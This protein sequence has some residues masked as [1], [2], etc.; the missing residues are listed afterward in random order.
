MR[1]EVA[2]VGSGPAGF[3]VAE[4]LLRSV[5]DCRIDLYERLPAPYGLVRYGVAPDHQ[6]L[7]SVTAIFDRIAADPRIGLAC[8]VEVGVDI[9]LAELRANHHCVI[10]ACGSPVGRTLGI[11]GE[12]LD[13]VQSSAN[14]VG[15][16][17]GHPDHGG[18][19]PR[20]DHPVAVVAG[21]GNVAMDVCRLLCKDTRELA[22]YDLTPDALAAFGTSRVREVHLVSRSAPGSAKCTVK[23]LRELASLP[24]VRVRFAQPGV[25][26]GEGDGELQAAWREIASRPQPLEATHTLHVWFHTMPTAFEGDGRLAAVRLQTRDGVETAVPCGIAITCIGYRGQPPAG[27][28]FD[29]THGVVPNRDGRVLDRT[30]QPVN[31]LY[32]VGWLKRG[33]TGVIGTNRADA[34][35]TAESVLA[36]LPQLLDA[37]LKPGR[38][39][40]R[41]LL[42]ARSIVPLDVQDWGRLDLWEKE[43]G[44]PGGAIRRKVGSLAEARSVLASAGHAHQRYQ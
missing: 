11:P 6:K 22:A 2:V 32:V 24:H 44:R 37:A 28:P 25:L 41:L 19:Q 35:A 23:E 42:D 5:V 29:E 12:Q 3:Y 15:W 33:P 14:F 43:Q 38:E 40:V 13:G 26:D 36:D 18:A 10:L 1:A 39:A 27:I 4:A 17:N 31:G 16:Y 30:E 20:L 9:T 34:V 8:G 21:M 7:K